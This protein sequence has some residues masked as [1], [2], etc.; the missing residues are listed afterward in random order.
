MFMQSRRDDL[1]AVIAGAGYD[2]MTQCPVAGISERKLSEYEN[3]RYAVA[4]S[5]QRRKAPKKNK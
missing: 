4:V 1:E 3:S 5:S 2:Y